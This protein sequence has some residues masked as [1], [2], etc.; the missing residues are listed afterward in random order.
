[1]YGFNTLDNISNKKL[2]QQRNR[3]WHNEFE[4][5][6]QAYKLLKERFGFDEFRP[7]QEAAINCTLSKKDCLALIPTGGGKSLIF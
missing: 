4:W 7:H 6:T 2:L 1:M 5:T 3:I